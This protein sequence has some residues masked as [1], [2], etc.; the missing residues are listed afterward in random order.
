MVEVRGMCLRVAYTYN[1]VYYSWNVRIPFTLIIVTC[2]LDVPAR[3]YV[4]HAACT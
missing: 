4:M 2:V 3:C 1:I